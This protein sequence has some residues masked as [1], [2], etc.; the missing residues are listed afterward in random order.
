V[1]KSCSSVITSLLPLDCNDANATCKLG[2]NLD[3]WVFQV[4]LLSSKLTRKR[5]YI[6]ECSNGCFTEP[7]P[8]IPR[9]REFEW[10]ICTRAYGQKYT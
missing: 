8:K 2:M 10:Q 5:I 4:L 9:D 7:E 6:F 1:N 3:L